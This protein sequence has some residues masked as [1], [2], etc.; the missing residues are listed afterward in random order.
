MDVNEIAR[1][2][3][4]SV[5]E[6]WVVGLISPALR[7]TRRCRVPTT[8]TRLFSVINSIDLPN[9]RMP[10]SKNKTIKIGF[11]CSNTPSKH[12][13]LNEVPKS[14]CIEFNHKV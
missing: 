13:I 1:T 12:A 3:F 10:D 11:F 9:K 2:L 7:A 4:V 5:W 14:Y 8:P 6:Q